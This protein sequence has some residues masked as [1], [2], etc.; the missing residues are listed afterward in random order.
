MVRLL[1]LTSGATSDFDIG[2]DTSNDKVVIAYRDSGN[3]HHGTAVVATASGT[4]LSYGTH[5][6]FDSQDCREHVVVYDSSTDRV[7]IFLLWHR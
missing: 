6:V 1:L 3:S 2:Y 7:A 5:A 4:T